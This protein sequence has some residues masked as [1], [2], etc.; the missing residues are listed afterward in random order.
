MISQQDAQGYALEKLARHGAALSK[1]MNTQTDM[2]MLHRTRRDTR[3][4]RRERLAQRCQVPP[5]WVGYSFLTPWRGITP[6]MEFV[7]GSDLIVELVLGS[8]P[9][10][11]VWVGPPPPFLRLGWGGTPSQ[12][13]QMGSDPILGIVLGVDPS[14]PVCFGVG[15]F[16][17]LFVSYSSPVQNPKSRMK[18]LKIVP[19]PK[20][21]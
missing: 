17:C 12:P 14:T 19:S 6:E 13:H 7:L 11:G 10:S 2:N 15:T 8:D 9:R 1:N 18:P 5:L 3:P 20:T 16:D 21:I 4:P